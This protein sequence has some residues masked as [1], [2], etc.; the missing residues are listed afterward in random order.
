MILNIDLNPYIDKTCSLDKLERGKTNRSNNSKYSLGG[1]IAVSSLLKAFGEDSFIS[2]FLGGVSGDRYH[3][4]L[5]DRMIGHE[6]VSIKDESKTNINII[7]DEDRT[8]RIIDREPRVTRE[9]MNKFVSLY[10][11]LIEDSDIICGSSSSL[12]LGLTENIYYKLIS[13][14][15]DKSKRF[16]LEAQGEALKNGIEAKP[17]MVILDKERLEELTNIILDYENEIIKAANY[18]LH[19]GVEFVVIC[20]PNSEILLLGQEKGMRISSDQLLENMPSSSLNKVSA[21]FALSIR[22][23]Y[24]LD[25]TARLAYAF[26][27]YQY[28][29][30][31]M[32]E[33]DLS[34]IKRIMTSVETSSISYA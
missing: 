31:S 9:D 3:K 12:P 13:I 5:F 18:I 7:H 23:N 19:R 26:Y 14:A 34:E 16:I 21:A 22:R 20:L 10:T 25:M 29:G 28:L 17:Y 15:R 1:N 27:V 8:T 6:F 30:G 33:I 11:K 2:G 24:D 4:M 32:E